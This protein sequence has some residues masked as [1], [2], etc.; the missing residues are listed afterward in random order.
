M[1]SMIADLLTYAQ[2]AVSAQCFAPVDLNAIAR[3]V[4]AD[5]ETSIAESGGVVEVGPLPVIAADAAQMRQLLQNLIGNALKF[6]RR[7]VMPF[8][9]LRA[10]PAGA[11]QYVVHVTD[12]GIGIRP[13]HQDRIFR[14]FERLHSRREF[15]GSGIG[16]AV[17]RRIVDRHGG[18][19]VTTSTI[20]HGTTFTVTLPATHA[21][22]EYAP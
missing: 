18:S 7:D 20:G 11:A 19:I 13:E 14:M 3:D 10:E 1:R 17:C 22:A 16:L 12:N 6:R 15:D 5:L 2:I 4:L 21:D 9:Q 8:V